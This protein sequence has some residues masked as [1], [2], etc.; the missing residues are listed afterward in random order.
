LALNDVAA[1]LRTHDI[2]PSGVYIAH[3][4]MG[5]PRYVGRGDIFARLR[6]HR[7]P[8]VIAVRESR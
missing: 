4:S 5:C 3:D 2:E 6:A 1:E 7:K 8:S